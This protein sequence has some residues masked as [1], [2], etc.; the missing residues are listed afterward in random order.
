MHTILRTAAALGIA[1][2]C[3]V[4]LNAQ[5][6]ETKTT[7]ETKV[8]IKG[9]KDVTVVGCL[10]RRDGG[11]YALTDVRDERR[12]APTRYAL[13][14]TDDL[15]KH[16]GQRVEVRG[17]AVQDGDGKVSIETKTKVEV[18]NGKDQESKLKTEATSGAMDM[19]FIG[20]NSVKM[21]ATSCN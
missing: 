6:Q 10:E 2:M 8:E 20:V 19:S 16:V 14:T 13:V 18:E 1:T 15:S 5:T 17:K 3:G 12:L 11:H 9:G 7:T 21:V 4:G